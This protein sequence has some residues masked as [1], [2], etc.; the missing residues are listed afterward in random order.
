MLSGGHPWDQSLLGDGKRA[1]DCAPRFKSCAGK[2]AVRHLVRNSN[3]HRKCKSFFHQRT[4][5]SVT[6]VLTCSAID[7]DLTDIYLQENLRDYHF[8][9][10]NKLINV[11]TSTLSSSSSSS[12][13]S[14]GE[15]YPSE[16]SLRSCRVLD[17]IGSH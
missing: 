2:K 15:G 14:H 1:T 7:R 9:S 6:V 8:K 12:S 11:H 10:E 17:M 5:G 3:K 13:W 16:R 4:T